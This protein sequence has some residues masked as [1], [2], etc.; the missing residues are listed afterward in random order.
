MLNNYFVLS[1]KQSNKAT[2]VM[3]NMEDSM[4]NLNKLYQYHG[5]PCLFKKN[6][7]IDRQ[8]ETIDRETNRNNKHF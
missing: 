4:I 3:F 5:Y 1:C 7:S 2:Y 8:L 6:Y